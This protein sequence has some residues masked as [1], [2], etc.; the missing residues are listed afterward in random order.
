MGV[1]RGADSRA[2]CEP[3][4][5]AAGAGVSSQPHRS[6]L[7]NDTAQGD[8]PSSVRRMTSPARLPP[9]P[10][11]NLVTGPDATVQTELP[12]LFCWY[13]SNKSDGAFSPE[14][15]ACV[16]SALNC[17]KLLHKL[18][19]ASTER[20]GERAREAGRE[21]GREEKREGGREK[22]Y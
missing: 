16:G 22:G 2:P 8:Q 17:M 15:G 21:G 4:H 13:M 11:S 6:L 20:E 1:R 10:N 12:R 18:C 3:L 19:Q 5:E 9:P 7:F 14:Q